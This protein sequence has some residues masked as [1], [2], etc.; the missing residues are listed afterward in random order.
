LRV[1][2]KLPFFLS[3]D[4]P[5]AIAPSELVGVAETERSRMGLDNRCHWRLQRDWVDVAAGVMVLSEVAS[6]S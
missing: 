4:A 1:V 2:V 6:A 3:S 5:V